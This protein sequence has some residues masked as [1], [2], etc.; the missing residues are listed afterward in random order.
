[1]LYFGKNHT[2]SRCSLFSCLLKECPCST[3][4]HRNLIVSRCMTR[5]IFVHFALYI[6]T[7]SWGM[8][9]SNKIHFFACTTEKKGKREHV[10]VEVVGPRNV[11]TKPLD[12][13]ASRMYRKDL[14]QFGAQYTGT[15]RSC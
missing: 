3:K 15:A 7:V 10:L 5:L 2:K 14:Q 8:N 13:V 6:H 4:R 12:C 9:D 1:M 11:T